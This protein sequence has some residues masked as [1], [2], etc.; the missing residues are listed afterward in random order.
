M[1]DVTIQ[2]HGL[3][4]LEARLAQLPDAAR[5]ALA[6]GLYQ[7]AHRVMARSAEEVPVETGALRSTG[8]VEEPAISGDRVSLTLGYGGPA[9]PYALYVH[10]NLQ[11]HHHVGRA[12]YLEGP[13]MELM[14]ELEATVARVLGEALG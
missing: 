4:E 10:E 7:H 9:A 13:A 6:A 2:V 12:K 14:P 11:A 8:H 5:H 1:A 3:K